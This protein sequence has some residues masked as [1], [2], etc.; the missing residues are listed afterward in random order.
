MN[1]IVHP[2]LSSCLQ[3]AG[4]LLCLYLFFSLKVDIR[5]AGRKTETDGEA[6]RSAVTELRGELQRLNQTA[7]KL[8]EPA[9]AASGLNISKRWQVLRLHSRGEPVEHIATTLLLPRQE[10]ELLLKVQEIGEE[11]A[12]EGRD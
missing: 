9:P 1:W 12:A 4:V 2:V 7:A 5:R 8:A 10:V 11:K 6:V 3:I